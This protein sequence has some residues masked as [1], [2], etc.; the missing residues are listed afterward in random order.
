M[1]KETETV[2]LAKGAAVPYRKQA[3]QHIHSFICRK[4]SSSSHP[5][6]KDRMVFPLKENTVS[7]INQAMI[8]TAG[9]AEKSEHAALSA[10]KKEAEGCA[11]NTADDVGHLRNVVGRNNAGDNFLTQI[12]RHHKNHRQRNLPSFK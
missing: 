6:H 10:F 2:F 12:K 1:R 11:G 7:Q 5:F 9:S 3:L 8:Q 4:N